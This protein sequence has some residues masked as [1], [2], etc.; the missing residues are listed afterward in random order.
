MLLNNDSKF[1]VF[2]IVTP[3][4]FLV[5]CGSLQ[6]GGSDLPD[7]HTLYKQESACQAVARKQEEEKETLSNLLSSADEE[8]N[9]DA[10]E[11]FD[12]DQ[13]LKHLDYSILYAACGDA[14]KSVASFNKADEIF[15][16]FDN[17]ALISLSEGGEGVGSILWN[18]NV[19]SYKGEAYERIL[20]STYQTINY[21]NSGRYNNARIEINKAYDVL[22]KEKER[23]ENDFYEKAGDDIRSENSNSHQ[24]SFGGIEEKLEAHNQEVELLAERVENS[25]ENGFTY[26]MVAL[27]DELNGD[28]DKAYISLKRGHELFPE[29]VLLLDNLIRVASLMNDNNGVKKGKAAWKA[30]TGKSWAPKASESMKRVLVIV[31]N[32]LIPEKKEIKLPI[33]LP[34]TIVF[35]AYPTLGP[36]VH[37]HNGFVASAPEEGKTSS[38][39][40]MAD[41]AALAAR[42]HKEKQPAVIA[43][44]VTRG[45][46]KGITT[47]A[48]AQ[49]TGLLGSLL[50]TVFNAVSESAD[51][52]TW[53]TLPASVDLIELYVQPNTKEIIISSKELENQKVKVPLNVNESDVEIVQLYAP[54]QE[55]RKI[56]DGIEKAPWR[57]DTSDNEVITSTAPV[58][59]SNDLAN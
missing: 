51:L 32:G 59:A 36:S 3:I 45:I 37:L 6:V 53:K 40:Q 56:E 14:N 52:R 55:L 26:F 34:D 24:V 46:A 49:D 13:L 31:N 57:E 35:A 4:L 42:N 27:T 25:Y 1:R 43:R 11:A 29:N 10:E 18:D 9:A 39:T 21:L 28:I 12:E 7:S 22:E 8:A 23:V 44:L 50:T 48:V 17:K 33:P 16:H 2:L 54:S 58:E 47:S 20:A 30:L 19:L 15:Q 41:V 38:S 5:G